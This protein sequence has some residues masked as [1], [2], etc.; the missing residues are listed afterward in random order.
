MRLII[1]ILA[2]IILGP[3]K[4]TVTYASPAPGLPT[5]AYLQNDNQLISSNLGFYITAKNTDW[6]LINQDKPSVERFAV[7][8]PK[9]GN[10]QLSIKINKNIKQSSLKDYVNY[11]RQDYQRLGLSIL[12]SQPIKINNF[13]GFMLDLYNEKTQIQLRQ[14]LLFKRP[15]AV[16]LTCSD[17]KD[18]FTKSFK[19][20]N[21]ILK[22][23][24]WYN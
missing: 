1:F 24:A 2:I 4:S 22:T 12:K 7:F 13:V 5:S 20:C 16:I 8:K 9:K 18:A 14:I 3:A 17:Q 6:S 21:K 15:H 10:A 11:W 19:E 23:F